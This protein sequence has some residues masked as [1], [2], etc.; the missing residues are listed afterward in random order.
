MLMK[1]LKPKYQ[2]FAEAIAKGMTGED[3]LKASGYKSCGASARNQ[4][5]RMM[6]N[7]DISAEIARLR[8]I[9]RNSNI[10]SAAEIKEGLSRMMKSAEVDKNFAGY[11]SL[12][13]KLCKMEGYYEPEKLEHKIV[14]A[15]EIANRIRFVSPLI[16]A[17]LAMVRPQMMNP[18]ILEV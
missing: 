11:S 18:E 17:K 5:T 1:P 8:K 4:A 14:S 13:D 16:A 7:D 12:A 15:E 3:A 6:T 2:L 10:L 9:S